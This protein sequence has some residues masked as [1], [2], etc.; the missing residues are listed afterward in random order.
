[1]LGSSRVTDSTLFK[2]NIDTNDLKSLSVMTKPID[3]I[4]R[5]IVY[6]FVYLLLIHIYYTHL[7][8]H[9]WIRRIIARFYFYM[10]AGLVK[11]VS[12][13]SILIK[14]NFSTYWYLTFM[15][16]HFY[17]INFLII[18]P[19]QFLRVYVAFTK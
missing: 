15:Q 6:D 3:F 14:F 19:E 12:L 8:S 11:F 13:F 4:F 18:I 10:M 7:N 16:G 2:H 1:M 17:F 5:E 9:I